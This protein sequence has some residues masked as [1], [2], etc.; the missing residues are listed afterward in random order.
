M[1]VQAI[2]HSAIMRPTM[3]GE[4]LSGT[5]G[6]A[7]RQQV[8]MLHGLGRTKY[9]MSALERYL[10]RSGFRT[11]NLG[12][13]SRS[14][15]IGMIAENY[16]APAVD[17]AAVPDG[18]P[19]H[20]VGHSL[21]GLVVRHYLRDHAVPEGS[22]LVMIG[23]PNGG[24]ELA[25]RLMR[26]AWYGWIMGPAAMQIGTA[27]DS[28]PNLLG[29]APVPVGVIA[30]TRSCLPCSRRIFHGPNDGKVAVERTR[31]AGMDDFI[32]LPCGHTFL[33]RDHTVL[34]QVAHFLRTGAFSRGS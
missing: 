13:P 32:A 14:M 17:E 2:V 23:P 4:K 33:A 19:I 30:G 7:D 10:R 34:E 5:L 12:Y 6:N 8:I 27:A 28:L 15:D 11:L 16:L 18:G 22:R 1:I 20:F 24:S 31:L 25:D 21:G 26:F 29:P 3:G 9:A